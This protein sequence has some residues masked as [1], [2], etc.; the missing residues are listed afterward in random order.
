MKGLSNA[1]R[2]AES[3]ANIQRKR[4]H[5][6]QLV[7]MAAEGQSLAGKTYPTNME[8]FRAYEDSTLGL[9]RI[10][11]PK[12]LNKKYSPSRVTLIDE[13]ESNLS[14]L[15]AFKSAGRARTKKPSLSTQLASLKIERDDLKYLVGRLVSQ[16]AIL[17]DENHKLRASA[18]AT[19]MTK[20]LTSETIKELNKKVVQLGGSLLKRVKSDD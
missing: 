19:E 7:A 5:L 17:L 16:V 18:R 1:Q 2:A 4:A 11:S 9:K 13:I 10:G 20:A 12:I 14:K 15:A 8:E 6:T 3:N